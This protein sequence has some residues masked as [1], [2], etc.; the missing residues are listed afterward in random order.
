[1]KLFIKNCRDIPNTIKAITEAL[2]QLLNDSQNGVD[3]SISEHKIRRSTAQNDFYWLNCRD[4]ARCLNQAKMTWGNLKLPYT[5]K[6]VHESNKLVFGI[7]TTTKMS[8]KEFADYMEAVFAMWQ[9]Y[10]NYGWTPLESPNSYLE[11]TGLI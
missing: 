11:R 1:M 6:V 2:K 9:D 4:I 3:I 10:S 5:D 8:T 7:E